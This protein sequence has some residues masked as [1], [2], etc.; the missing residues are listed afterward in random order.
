MIL[1]K[2]KKQPTERKDYDVD[3]SPWLSP[4]EDSIDEVDI[5]VTCL[6]DPLDTDLVVSVEFTNN[7]IKLWV[8]QGTDGYAYKVTMLVHTVGTRKDESEL[9]FAIGDV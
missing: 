5:S 6:D 7:K 2:F 3:C 4:L 8:D 9:I 1:K